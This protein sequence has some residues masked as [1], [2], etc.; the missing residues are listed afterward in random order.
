MQYAT[1]KWVRDA[2]AKGHDFTVGKGVDPKGPFWEP[3]YKDPVFLEKLDNFLAAVAKR[4]D[5]NPE[6]AFIDV[7]T[8]GVWG[9]GHTWASTR[10]EYPLETKQ[11]HVDLHHKHFKET[12]LVI[13]DDFAGPEVAKDQ[14]LIDHAFKLGMTLRDDSILV[15]PKERAY[16]HAAMAKP[17]WPLRP[18]ILEHEHYGG[19][20]I[21]GELGRRTALTSSG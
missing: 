9:E 2:G 20:Q 3:D 13:C 14:A 5:G 15:Q 16:F 17:F 6:V 18:V 1:P 8:Y 21:P 10:I 11:I 4:Y 19:S 12:L 7:G